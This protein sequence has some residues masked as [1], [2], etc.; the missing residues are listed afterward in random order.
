MRV[1]KVRTEGGLS[2]W[3]CRK[4]WRGIIPRAVLCHN[5]IDSENCLLFS[6][7]SVF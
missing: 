1:Q 3:V 7:L 5:I 6:S 2:R 4:E